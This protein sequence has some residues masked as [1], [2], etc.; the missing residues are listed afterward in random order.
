MVAEVI[1]RTL[2]F[3]GVL[4]GSGKS[5]RDVEQAAEVLEPVMEVGNGSPQTDRMTVRGSGVAKGSCQEKSKETVESE[6]K[7]GDKASNNNNNMLLACKQ[8]ASPASIASAKPPGTVASKEGEKEVK[9]VEMREETPLIMIAEVEPA[10][11][12]GAVEGEEE[13]EV[14]A[15]D[16]DEDE[17]KEN[18]DEERVQQRHATVTGWQQQIG[19]AR[20][21][22]SFANTANVGNIALW[23]Q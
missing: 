4:W 20:G 10:V 2:E 18:K 15:I 22:P 19:V 5:P 23:V 8:S 12:G 9:D 13:V 6:D 3:S 7:V 14:E 11:S 21:R 1:W 16:M 17:D